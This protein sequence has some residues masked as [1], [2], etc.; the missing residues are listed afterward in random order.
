MHKPF[1]VFLAAGIMIFLLG[2]IPYARVGYLMIQRGDLI[3]GHIQ[4]LIL[5]GVMIILGFMVV[6]IGIVADLLS[7]N[8]KLIEDALRKINEMKYGKQP[9]DEVK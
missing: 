7:I 6:F 9:S 8:R 3:G 5:G 1:K 2:T 4:S